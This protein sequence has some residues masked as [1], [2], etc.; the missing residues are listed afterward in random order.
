MYAFRAGLPVPPEVA[1]LSIKRIKSGNITSAQV[2]QVLKTYTPEQVV[3]ARFRYGLPS[4][5]LYDDACMT[6]LEQHYT[7]AYDDNWQ[8]Q[9]LRNDL[10]PATNAS[11]PTSAPSPVNWRSIRS[12]LPF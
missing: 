9:Y 7:K 3:L 8:V 11:K 10:W 6:Y 4:V 1:V 5:Q 2:L 12:L